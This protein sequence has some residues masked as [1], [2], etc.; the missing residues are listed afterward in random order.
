MDSDS[1][2]IVIENDI[3]LPRP[4]TKEILEAILKKKEGE[5]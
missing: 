1:G 3:R 2:Y 4:I 5:S